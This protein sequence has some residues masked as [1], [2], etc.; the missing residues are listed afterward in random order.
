ML[1]YT[2]NIIFVEF[3]TGNSGRITDGINQ[4]E[5]TIDI[6]KDHYDLMLNC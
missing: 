3:K 6:Y 1:T 4:L 5:T 2:D